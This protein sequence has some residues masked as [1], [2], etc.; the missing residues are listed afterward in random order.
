MINYPTGNASQATNAADV[1]ASVVA[2]GRRA[3]VVAAD[4]A[5]E[6]EVKAMVGA[7]L[8]EFGKI[9]IL[10]NNAGMASASPVEQMPEEMWDTMCVPPLARLSCLP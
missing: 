2:L 5:K 6:A 8:S 10:V 1:A 9:D 3:L 7:A 4:V